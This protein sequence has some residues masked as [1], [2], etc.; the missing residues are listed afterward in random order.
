M[1]LKRFVLCYDD[2]LDAN[3][4]KNAI[5]LF[6]NE[7]D[8][9]TRQDSDLCGFSMLNIT[10]EVEKNQNV[11]FNPVHQQSLLAIKSCGEKYMK[12]LDCER[13]WPRQN[14]LEQVKMMKFQHRTADHFNRH[15]D[16][17]D[18]ASARRFVAYHMFLNDDFEDGDIYF[19]DIDYAIPAKRGRVVMFPATWTF[20][21]SYRAPK[22]QDKYA[23]ITYLHY[24]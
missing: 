2:V 14:S 5:D 17:G 7:I 10:E 8:K 13:Y 3:Y 22:E 9:I 21:H 16:V 20:A 15:I 18:Y 1:D 19:D 11:K 23:L 4:C 12:E 6:D 24:T